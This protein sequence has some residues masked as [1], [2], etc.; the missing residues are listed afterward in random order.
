MSDIIPLHFAQKY[1]AAAT[2]R[3]KV[4]VAAIDLITEE[5]IGAA[6]RRRI[7]ERAGVSW[8]AVQQIFSSQDQMLDAIF[9][10]STEQLWI[11]L[12][13][14]ELKE[15]ALS[16][17]VKMFVALCWRHYMS[18]IALATLE[19]LMATRSRRDLTSI[20][21]FN[22]KHTS[23]QLKRVREIFPE[24]IAWDD[25]EVMEVLTSLH[26]GLTG[27]AVQTVFRPGM[28]NI[29]GYLRRFSRAMEIML[30]E[31]NK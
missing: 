7:A 12:E 22:D 24:T 27:L 10:R 29:G 2:T 15:G 9:D 25:R 3:E 20:K 5:G 31:G 1:R 11:L 4:I 13:N 19:M 26:C 17:R 8:G 21:R 28:G 18:D 16:E 14:R 6:S 23:L 30:I